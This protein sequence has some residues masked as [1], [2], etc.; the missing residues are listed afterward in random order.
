M[1]GISKFAASYVRRR[2]TERMDD[3]CRIWTPGKPVL[4]RNTGTSS[5][6]AE[7]TK[8][9]GPCRFWEVPVSSQ[10]ILGEE[11][12]VVT[13]TFL[14]LPFDAPVPESDDIIKITGSADPDLVGRTVSVISIMRGGGLRASRRFLVRLVDSKKP[15]W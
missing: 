3:T 13:Q 15:T 2:T 8:Y 6:A 9:E 10:V 5:R 11:Q 1:V 12:V 14:S 4:N 7:E